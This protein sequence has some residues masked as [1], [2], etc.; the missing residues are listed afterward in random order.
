MRYVKLSAALARTD[1]LIIDEWLLEPLS[2][3]HACAITRGLAL[4]PQ[5]SENAV[6]VA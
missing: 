4:A 3:S 5:P 1:L 2:E 6:Y